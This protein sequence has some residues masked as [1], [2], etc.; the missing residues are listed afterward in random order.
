MENLPLIRHLVPIFQDLISLVVHR[1]VWCKICMDW[2]RREVV[3]QRI[4]SQEGV[5]GFGTRRMY[6][7]MHA[8]AAIPNAPL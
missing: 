5:M 3:A 1:T 6:S 8:A 7:Q 4:R 2:L